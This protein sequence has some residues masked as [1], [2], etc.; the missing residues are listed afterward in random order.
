[1]VIKTFLNNNAPDGFPIGFILNTGTHKN[2]GQHWQ[3]LYFDNEGISYFFDS[4]GRT[5]K[6]EFRIFEILLRAFFNYCA[7]F[8][9]NTST[10]LHQWNINTFINYGLKKSNSKYK[11]YK[12]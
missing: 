6:K 9:H 3:A 5:A 10:A 11:N 1:M 8:N 4:Y 12:R 7:M 2:G